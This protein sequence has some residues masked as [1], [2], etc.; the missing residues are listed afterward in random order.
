[1]RREVA[2]CIGLGQNQSEVGSILEQLDSIIDSVK[3]LLL[4]LLFNSVPQQSLNQTQ[5]R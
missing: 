3:H 4:Q 2:M 1:M 5:M